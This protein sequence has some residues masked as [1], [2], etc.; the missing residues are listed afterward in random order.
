MAA[1]ENKLEL[2]RQIR[3]EHDSNI[4]EIQNRETILYGKPYSYGKDYAAAEIMESTGRQG[5]A[6]PVGMGFFLRC[7][8]TLLLCGGIYYLVQ[9]PDISGES[10]TLLLSKEQTEQVKTVMED[11]LTKNDLSFDAK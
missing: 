11:W 2:L 6:Y 7:V 10:T 5:R 9:Q 1:T 8:L 4:R 3:M